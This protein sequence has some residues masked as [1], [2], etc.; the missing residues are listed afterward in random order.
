[1]TSE[2]LWGTPES[3]RSENGAWVR[4]LG[5]ALYGLLT[6]MLTTVGYIT[7]TVEPVA[8]IATIVSGLYILWMYLSV[9]VTLL[10]GIAPLVGLCITTFTPIDDVWSAMVAAIVAGFVLFGSIK[11]TS[12]EPYFSGKY[13]LSALMSPDQL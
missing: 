8:L 12:V 3:G 10:I 1:M 4:V 6:L 2:E 11:N 9:A 7:N 13:A 5:T